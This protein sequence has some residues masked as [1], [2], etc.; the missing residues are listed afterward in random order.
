M[1]F[2][3]AIG[4]GGGW[5]ACPQL[6]AAPAPGRGASR[7]GGLRWPFL[8]WGGLRG[9]GRR[10]AGVKCATAAARHA[11]AVAPFVV[12]WWARWAVVV[13]R[14]EGRRVG[15]GA[16][17]EGRGG[18]GRAVTD[19][20]GCVR[21]TSARGGDQG[22]RQGR[23]GGAPT[24]A[25]GAMTTGERL[26]AAT[27]AAVV[28]AMHTVSPGRQRGK[29]GCGVGREGSST[30]GPRRRTPPG[31]LN[32]GSPPPGTSRPSLERP[33]DGR[34][35]TQT[36]STGSCLPRQ[37]DGVFTQTD[38]GQIKKTERMRSFRHPPPQ[39]HK[40]TPPQT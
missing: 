38:R 37:G 27:R 33:F 4:G 32:H 5:R 16:G 29:D 11:L 39:T 24:P 22:S 30:T 20:R 3:L 8:G 9:G 10:L 23:G 25:R 36:R 17:Q 12:G 2:T 15:Q 34:H 14:R 13:V 26:A 35:P 1:R 28:L 31:V 19:A 7:D 6:A 21:P 18:G 40:A